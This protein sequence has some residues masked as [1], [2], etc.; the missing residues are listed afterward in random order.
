MDA[1]I[2]HAR[3]RIGTC[4][5]NNQNMS[6]GVPGPRTTMRYRE[7]GLVNKHRIIM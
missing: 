4:I 7:M 3:M 1:Q 5:E 6:E 2:N